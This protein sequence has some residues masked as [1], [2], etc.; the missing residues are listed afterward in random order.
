M[1]ILRPRPGLCEISSPADVPTCPG[2]QH[3]ERR[4]QIADTPAAF[5][6]SGP[7]VARG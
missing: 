4:I 1:A 3:L 7:T 6:D 2:L 5:T